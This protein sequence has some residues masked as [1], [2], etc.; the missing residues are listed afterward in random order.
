MITKIE[1][2]ETTTE[3]PGSD[4]YDLPMGTTWTDYDIYVLTHEDG[5]TQYIKIGKVFNS[6][7]DQSGSTAPQLVN[8]KTVS[9][10]V[11]E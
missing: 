9:V 2:L 8:P 3:R 6:Y 5:S 7:G 4:Y 10:N 11:W 1:F